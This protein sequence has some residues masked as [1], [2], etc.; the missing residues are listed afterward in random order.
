MRLPHP[1]VPLSFL[2]LACASGASAQVAGQGVAGEAAA[3]FNA[4]GLVR[5]GLFDRTMDSGVLDRYREELQPSFIQIGAFEL[6][7]ALRA[8][9][10]Y[11][12]NVL[13]G[14]NADSDNGFMIAPSVAIQSNWGR[15]SASVFARLDGR[16][17]VNHTSENT[18]NFALGSNNRLDL[19]P[20]S[21]VAFGASYERSTESRN[22]LPSPQHAVDPEQFNLATAYIGGVK[23]LNRIRLVGSLS[24]K[25]YSYGNAYDELGGVIYQ[26]DRSHAV[27]EYGGRA[28]YALNSVSSVYV[29]LKGNQRTYRNLLSGAPSRNSSGFDAAI[30]ANLGLTHLI[31]GDVEIGYLDQSFDSS[32]YRKV[33]GTSLRGS[34][35][36][37]FSPVA[38]FTLVSSQQVGDAGVIGSAGYLQSNQTLSLAYELSR[39]LILTG[40]V[41]AE[42]DR[43]RDID[44]RDNRTSAGLGAK[45]LLNRSLGFLVNYDYLKSSSSGALRGPSYDEQQIVVSF[46]Y[47]L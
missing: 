42:Q 20:S 31:R 32:S 1:S 22:D 4:Q 28:E 5:N 36:Y 6:I 14:A 38:T 18:V 2:A 19:S 40:R 11:D 23:Q 46:V 41:G 12:S 27:T 24:L 29:S 13:A 17:Y 30:G 10:V 37:F 43:I 7:P 39:S 26:R 9:A 33:S 35:E 45:F 16:S 34:L 3:N 25:D 21:A 47:Q 15:N 8:G 44:R